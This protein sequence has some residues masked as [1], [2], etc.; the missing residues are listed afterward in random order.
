MGDTTT[1]PDLSTDL[2]RL[3]ALIP[4]G[5]RDEIALVCGA[6][7]ALGGLIPA[8]VLNDT[9]TRIVSAILGVAALLGSLVT[10]ANVVKASA[11]AVD[12]RKL[13]VPT[14]VVPPT[15]AVDDPRL[16]IYPPPAATVSTVD[17]QPG[18]ATAVFVDAAGSVTT[19]AL[20]VAGGP[21]DNVAP[22]GPPA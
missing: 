3:A 22:L 16:G 18:T 5:V 10:R 9:Q 21:D 20:P 4:E 11:V 14:V 13:G 6:V 15:N 19:E 7:V 8:A 12:R 1:D 2:G 17:L